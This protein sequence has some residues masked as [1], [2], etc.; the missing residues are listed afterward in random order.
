MRRITALIVLL[1]ISVPQA[2]AEEVGQ[3]SWRTGYAYDLDSGKLVYVEEH[4]RWFE[5]DQIVKQTINYYSATGA[6]IANKQLDFQQQATQPE[7]RLEDFRSQYVEGMRWVDGQWQVFCKRGEGKPIKDKQIKALSSAVVDAGFDQ[8]VIRH[9]AKLMSGQSIDVPF[10]IPSRMRLGEFRIRLLHANDS[11]V[12]FL[13]EPKSAFIR[14][15]F[16]GIEVAY[17][18]EQRTLLEYSG[19]S[20]LR[21]PE[22]DNYMVRIEFQDGPANFASSARLASP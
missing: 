5:D 16:D 22:L 1:F 8:F 4:A 7:F 6:A 19:M 10:L 13:L 14:W 20:N 11:K 17:H 3:P 18:P 12:R 21:D 9:W 2:L 15:F